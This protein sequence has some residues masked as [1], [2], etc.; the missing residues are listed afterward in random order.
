M[1]WVCIICQPQL[2][3][4]NIKGIIKNGSHSFFGTLRISKLSLGSF[5]AEV[6]SET[7]VKLILSKNVYSF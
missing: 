7:E 5:R 6:V 2:E 1:G 4:Q 3:K